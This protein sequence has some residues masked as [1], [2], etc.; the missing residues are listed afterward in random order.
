[1]YRS[2]LHKLVRSLGY[3]CMYDYLKRNHDGVAKQ[4]GRLGVDRR[5]IQYWKRKMKDGTCV[6]AKESMCYQSCPKGKTG[7]MP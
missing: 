1:M 7:A 2:V 6:C 4:A 5:Q 3:C